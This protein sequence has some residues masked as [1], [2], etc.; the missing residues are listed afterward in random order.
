MELAGKG[1]EVAK[2]LCG[3]HCCQ[4]IGEDVDGPWR[5]AGT[6]S[7]DC[8]KDDGPDG[9]ES[10]ATDRWL[11]KCAK[12]QVDNFAVFEHLGVVDG[13][14]GVCRAKDFVLGQLLEV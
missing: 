10:D 6:F 2:R 14:L 1:E 9:E 12:E 4:S 8:G 11:K 3:G 5:K 7:S 13:V